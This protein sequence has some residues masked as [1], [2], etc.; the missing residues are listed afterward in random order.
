MI[1]SRFAA[2]RPPRVPPS[3][4]LAPPL[5]GSPAAANAAAYLG[6]RLGI[7]ALSL[8]HARS[9]GPS[10]VVVTLGH[11]AGTADPFCETVRDITRWNA[12]IA[13]QP[14]SLRRALGVSDIAA[15]AAAGQVGVIYGFQNTQMLGREADRV[16]LFAR[17]GVRVM[18]LTYDGRNAVGDGAL[19]ADDRGLSPFGLQVVER[20]QAEGVLVDLGHS[21]EKTCLDAL[22][23]ARR[24]L[25]ITHTGCRAVAEHP[26][27]KSDAELRVLAA[28]GGVAGLLFRPC[29]RGAGQAMAADVLAHLEHAL[30]VCGEDHVALG[31]HGGA[32][33][34][35]DLPAWRRQRED[36]I[37]LGRAQGGGVPGDSAEVGSFL[38][39][40]CSPAQFEPLADLLAARGHAGS[41]IDKILGGNFRRVMAE[42][43]THA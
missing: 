25:A 9:A 13:Q 36:E 34:H 14:E 11:V 15:A 35:E 42:A 3:P 20:L 2:M 7:D 17:M 31:A 40:L 10:A 12:F 28:K 39:D 23:V 29:L 5:K 16:R 4:N 1:Q 43:W 19:V 24:P 22:G 41:R 37:A 26:R 18:Q 27:H 30:D 8:A 21:S 38:S 6:G 33:V 32:V